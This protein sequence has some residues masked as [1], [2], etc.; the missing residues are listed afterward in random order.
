MVIK[1]WK[2]Q[3]E[4]DKTS[5]PISASW[6]LKLP[7]P[8]IGSTTSNTYTFKPVQHPAALHGGYQDRVPGVGASLNHKMYYVYRIGLN[9]LS[10]IFTYN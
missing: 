5:G 8:E 3:P 4:T 9:P 2:P 1:F 6:V 7:L 10:S